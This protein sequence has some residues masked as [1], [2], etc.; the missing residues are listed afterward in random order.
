V[1]YSA[2]Q[3]IFPGIGK[4]DQAF[5]TIAD[6]FMMGGGGEPANEDTYSVLKGKSI[7]DIVRGD[8]ETLERYDMSMSDR[9]KLEAWKALLTGTIDGP[10]RAAMCD[11]SVA[12]LLG[13]TNENLSKAGGGSGLGGDAVT[14]EVTATLDAADIYSNVAALAALCDSN[15]VI[16]LKYP[17]NY[18]FRGLGLN[19]ENHSISHRVGSANMGGTCVSGVNDQIMTIDRYY[20]EKFAKLVGTL[21]S[22]PEGEGTLLDNCAAVWFQ[23][24]SDGNAHNLNNL[25]I[26]QAGSCGGYFKTGQAINVEDGDPDLSK[27]NSEAQCK[28]GGEIPFDQVTASASPANV[29]NAPINKYFCNLMNAIG[30]KAGADGFPAEGGSAEVTHFGM[31]DKT[32]DFIG[33]GTNPATIHDPGEFTDL[34][35]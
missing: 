27:G 31:Y 13:L 28:N 19:T 26:V 2:A 29:A 9:Q 8:L 20:T 25:P 4:P 18:V 22:L 21:D 15:R 17:G 14:A 11:A 12:E 16:F 24:M 23:E 6:S 10:V 5:G 32:E 3:E 7:L 1:S 35:A 34:K 30:V 33:G